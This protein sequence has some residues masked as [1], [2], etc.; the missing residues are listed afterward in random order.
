MRSCAR[1]AKQGRTDVHGWLYD[2]HEGRLLTYDPRD[3]TWRDLLAG[4]A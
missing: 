1:A 2:M 3:G 4:E